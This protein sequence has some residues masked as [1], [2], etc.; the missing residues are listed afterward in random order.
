MANLK[1]IGYIAGILFALIIGFYL[2]IVAVNWEAITFDGN[3]SAGAGIRM[4]TTIITAIIVSLFFQRL[5]QANR[6]EKDLIMTQLG[7]ML[8][9]VGE[10][11]DLR[12]SREAV[13]LVAVNTILKKLRVKSMFVQKALAECSFGRKFN[14]DPSFNNKISEIRELTTST[15]SQRVEDFVES[16]RC[17]I[18]VREGLVTWLD[19]RKQEIE[20][21]LEEIKNEIFAFQLKINR[22]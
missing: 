18:Y 6:K 16:D 8:D 1:T 4:A 12:E 2:G 15:P 11:E 9:L 19:E 20:L 21:K 10:L 14:Q 22:A 13:E 7:L 17:P 5:L 3:V